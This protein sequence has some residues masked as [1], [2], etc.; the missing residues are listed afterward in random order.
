MAL[1]LRTR[2]LY[3]EVYQ[4]LAV[5]RELVLLMI[6]LL[7]AYTNSPDVVDVLFP[8]RAPPFLPVAIFVAQAHDDWQKFR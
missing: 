5:A 7:P 4:V 3:G 6:S 8:P 1:K 2:V